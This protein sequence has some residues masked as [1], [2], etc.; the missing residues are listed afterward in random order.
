MQYR[1]TFLTKTQLVSILSYFLFPL[2]HQGKKSLASIS[3]NLPATKP[4]SQFLKTLTTATWVSFSAS[5]LRRRLMKKHTGRTFQPSLKATTSF[6][7]SDRNQT[8]GFS[9]NFLLIQSKL[10]FSPFL[11]G[12]NTFFFPMRIWVPSI[13]SITNLNP[14]FSSSGKVAWSD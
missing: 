5:Y 6:L 8:R 9:P 10:L 12:V 1:Y 4:V 14:T 11:E 13:L 7:P 3:S 2:W